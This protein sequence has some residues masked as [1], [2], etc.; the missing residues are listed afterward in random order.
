MISI[1]LSLTNF[2]NHH[3]TVVE[4]GDHVNII[5]GPNGAGKTNLIDALHYLCMG[6]SFT[7][8]SDQYVVRQGAASF[9][10]KGLFRGNIR[11]QFE[12]ACA[13][14][15][16]EGKKLFVNDSPLERHA[17]LIGRVPVVLVSQ[18]DRK[19]T[20]EG[21]A[22]RRSFLDA[23]ISQTSPAYLDDLIRYRRIV[24]Q[25]NRLL[26]EHSMDRGYLNVLL[27]P[28]NRQLVETG[29]RII[30]G[31]N[32]MVSKFCKYLK[33]AHEQLAGSGLEPAI[34]YKTFCSD[35]Q[36]FLSLNNE[37]IADAYRSELDEAYE[38]ELDR[39]QTVIGPHRDDLVFFLDDMELRKFGSQ[40]QHRIFA[41]ALKMAQL[42]FYRDELEDL[43]VFL[44][45]DVFG[46]LD[47]SRTDT[48]MNMLL[49]H[50]GQSFIT[51]AHPDKISGFRDQEHA[52]IAWYD[53]KDG[54]V[55][56]TE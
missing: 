22:E 50:N 7:S 4:W 33:F 36:S 17:D 44:L 52:R 54:N 27:E 13:Y 32:K 10:I 1:T 53:V 39:R 47:P 31:R 12:I 19:L 34:S 18:N 26:F 24:R 46:D 35:Q 55:S 48:V 20:G 6:R 16:G 25:R 9:L 38:R 2:R 11:S 3:Q 42:Y 14:S 28:W 49:Q 8:S 51:A 21:P 15:R 37:E 40:G 23:L 41:L 43:P 30:S 5:T 56:S 29:A 45:D